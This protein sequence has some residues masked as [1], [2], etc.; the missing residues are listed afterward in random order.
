MP[1]LSECVR[2]WLLVPLAAATLLVGGCDRNDTSND[3]SNNTSKPESTLQPQTTGVSTKA[4][5][6]HIAAE[7]YARTYKEDLARSPMMQTYRGVKD[8]YDKWSD[9]SEAFIDQSMALYSARLQELG[10][11][12][13]D[14]LDGSQRLSVDLYREMLARSLAFDEFRHHDYILDQFSGWHIGIPS[15]LINMHQVKSQRDAEDYIKRLQAVDELTSDLIAQLDIRE[16][17]KI[18]PPAWSYPQML[19]AAN[20]VLRGKP[21]DDS[22][23]DS[24]LLQDFRKKVDQLELNQSDAERLLSAAEIALRED[25]KP[26]YD[27]LIATLTR[28]MALAS[29]DDGVWKLP[30]GDN[31]YRWLLN[32]YTTTDLDPEQVHQ[33]GLTHVNRIHNE[34]QEIMQQVKFD[35]SLQEFFVFMREDP[36]FYYEDSDEG[37]A[38]YLS[39]AQ[40]RID[41]VREKLPETF[42]LLPKAELMIKRVE[43]F[44]EKSAGKAFYQMP[45]ADG[46]RPGIYYANLYNMDSM[47]KY[48]LEALAYHEAIP[49]HHMQLAIA[50][51]LEGVPEFQKYARFTAYTEGWG[52]Y[53]EFL[54]KE[55]GF[56]QDPY[57]DFGRLTME[58]WRACRLVVDTG[59]HAKRWTRQE[60]IDYLIANTPN[61]TSDATKAIE[62]YIVY[63]GQ[64]T[65]YMIG[66]LK[67]LELREWSK[68]QLGEQFDIRD[69]HN[70]IL[71]HG[72]LPLSLLESQIQV[73]VKGQSAAG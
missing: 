32:Y 44:R 24:T 16:Q 70:Q 28:Q 14:S 22:D 19:E 31:Y 42:S 68:Q 11:I 52:L 38:D 43:S 46:S 71:M 64:A 54:A 23:Q 5:G 51:E 15:F 27:A 39:T 57:S 53:A 48:Q 56:Y 7:F 33:L 61:S 4:T 59:I 6:A 47:P 21:F 45:A 12:N 1:F 10:T 29:S 18:F 66:K 26:G 58:L 60:A 49:G 73:W 37:R 17:E 25:F 34:I 63:P 67:I 55:M 13:L 8:D 62:R 69:F 3:T 50:V 9:V 36:Q 35:G 65:A 2:H 40:R 20:N 30:N 72:P 41:D